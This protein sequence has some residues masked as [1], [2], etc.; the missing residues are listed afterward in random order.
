MARVDF[1]GTR[2]SVLSKFLLFLLPGRRLFVVK[3]VCVCIHI[4]DCLKNVYELPLLPNNA[5][6]IHFYT[7]RKV[8]KRW[9]DI[10]RWGAGQAVTGPIHGIGQNVL[11]SAFVTGS[12]S[13]TVTAT[14]CYLSH[15]AAAQ[16]LPHCYLS[17]V[18]EAQLLPHSGTYR[19]YQKHSYCHILLLIA[20]SSSTVTATFCYL[21]HVAAAPLLPHSVTYRM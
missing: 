15:V 7:N 4:S 1:L 19:M 14:F 17:Q 13:S 20:C 11:Q 5:A 10:Y 21:S 18:S 16:L 6:V 8:A 9:L 2:H 3:N 12:G